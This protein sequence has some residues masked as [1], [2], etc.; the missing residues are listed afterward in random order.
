MVD[1]NFEDLASGRRYLL[2][3]KQERWAYS[4]T[5]GWPG[6]FPK[7]MGCSLTWL[8]SLLLSVFKKEC[9][10]VGRCL[11]VN[12]KMYIANKELMFCAF[13]VTSVCCVVSPACVTSCPLKGIYEGGGQPS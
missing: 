13:G 1:V 10:V 5:F 11:N 6:K 12:C 3:G 2:G 4:H 8:S 9:A 7:S